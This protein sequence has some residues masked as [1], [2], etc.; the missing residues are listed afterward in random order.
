MTV[1]DSCK[2]LCEGLGPYCII[3]RDEIEM[4]ERGINRQCQDCGGFEFDDG[5][6]ELC[7]CDQND[8][9]NQR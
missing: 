4:I 2:E 7:Y 8:D 5:T 1:C 3:C 9:E 6:C